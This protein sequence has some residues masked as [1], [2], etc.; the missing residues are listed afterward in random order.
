LGDDVILVRLTENGLVTA[1]HKGECNFVVWTLSPRGKKE[2]LVNEIG[3]YKGTVAFEAGRLRKKVAAIQV[4]AEEEWSLTVKPLVGAS[5][6]VYASTSGAGDD[7]VLQIFNRKLILKATYRGGDNF[8]I[9]ALSVDGD[10]I[11]LL[12]NTSVVGA[13]RHPAWYQMSGCQRSDQ[14]PESPGPNWK[15]PMSSVNRT[16]RRLAGP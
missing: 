14:A 4:E 11:D 7:N 1:K 13:H 9:W 6:W 8:L 3:F 12:V 2:L 10:K 16:R 5:D 15:L